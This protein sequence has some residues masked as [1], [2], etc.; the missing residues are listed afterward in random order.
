MKKNLLLLLL[1]FLS[2]GA[3]AQSRATITGTILD[4]NSEPII[5]ASVRVLNAK[6][7]SYVN[8]AVSG[9][10][11][12]FSVSVNQGR[13]I[14]HVS[15]LGYADY[16]RN[17]NTAQGTSLGQIKLKESSVL[18][19]EAVITAKAVEIV[20]KDDT[21]EYNADSYKVQ[22]SAMVEDLVKRMPGAEVDSEGKITVNGKEVKKILLD[23]K[24]FFS[25]DPK[26]ASKNLPASMVDKLQ[27]FDKK[28][29]MAMMTGFDD[30]NEETVINLVVKPGMKEGVFG[31]AYAGYGSHDR[32]EANAMV[33]YMRNNNQFSFLGGLNNT[34]NAGFSDFA[35][36]MFGGNRPHRGMRFGGNNGITKSVNGGMNFGVEVSPKL[37]LGGNARYGSS[38]NTVETRTFTNYTLQDRLETRFGNG[39]N[40]SDNVGANLRMEWKPDDKTQITFRPSLQYN[41]NENYQVEDFW[42][43][44]QTSLTDTLTRGNTD[45][46]SKGDGITLSG[47]LNVS[48]KLSDS[49]RVLSFRVQGGLSDSDSD[50]TNK[51]STWRQDDSGSVINELQNQTFKQKDDSYNW[52][53]YVS[54]VEP[55][56]RNNFLQVDYSYRKNYSESDKKT[57]D[58][59]NGGAIDIDYT[60]KTENDFINQQVGLKFKSMRQKYNYTV[61]FAVQPSNS[62]TTI[63]SPDTTYIT[64]ND[65]VNFAPELQFNYNW[66]KRSNL[67]IEYN[68]N[69][70]QPTTAQLSD[71]K[72]TSDPLNQTVGNP[73]LK[74]SFENRLRIRFRKFNPEQGSAIMLFSNMSYTL[75]DIVTTSTLI[76]NVTYKTYKNVN[77]NF[78]G[79][80]RLIYNTPLRNKKFSVNSM[81]FAS[82]AHS[83][84][85]IDGNDNTANTL[86]L[87]ERLGVEYR[88]DLFDVSLRGNLS[89]YNIN[90]SAASANSSLQNQKT[91]DYGGTLGTTLYL[92]YNWTLE[93]DIEYSTNSGYENGYKLNQWLW[94][95]SISKQIFKDKNG[96]LRIK[97]YDILNDRNNI[98]RTSANGSYSDLS[99][100]T[101]NSYF[102]VHFVYKFQLFKGGAKASD[103]NPMG[104]GGFGGHPR[105]M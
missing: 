21:V 65:V 91:Y 15:Y 32:Y 57:Y 94:N 84:G 34:N 75:N 14:I 67:R 81:T 86:R 13:Y 18:L 33:N 61:G 68:G 100:S 4:S 25:D 83:K 98:T 46:Y 5:Q 29:D 72:I 96:T 53:G 43:T 77:G 17:L 23:G 60:R 24:E 27:V 41:K 88:S 55:V 36:S 66:D 39:D 99:T 95:A 47:D 70:N 28:S 11:G 20:V 63:I 82:Y 8:G 19:A 59:Q 22:Q 105:R 49:G 3:F 44:R 62:K 76:D 45:Y 54:Y 87:T 85:F 74:P 48:R 101:I 37:E 40:K 89:F 51:S 52:R 64:K 104:R 102:M 80:A 78:S 71:A 30:G 90:N 50:G 10:N 73:N 58:W 31:N 79:M 42:T 56:G 2:A 35:S 9:A 69:T 6:D 92:P 1:L 16:Y 93:T 12:K 26:V 97:M 7:S 103:M 38:D